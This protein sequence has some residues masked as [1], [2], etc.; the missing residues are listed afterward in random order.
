MD[1]SVSFKLFFMKL[2][3]ESHVIVATF[4]LLDGEVKY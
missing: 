1:C 4:L 2:R 3:Q